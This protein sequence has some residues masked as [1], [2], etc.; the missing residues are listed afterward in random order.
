M[1]VYTPFWRTLKARGRTTYWLIHTQG[2][3][4]SA[5]HRLR[6]NEGISTSLINE[7][8]KLLDCSVSD[9]LEFVPDKQ[10]T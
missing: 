4:G 2:M 5:I 9:I 8:C 1:I 7:L 3:S 10:E 6:H